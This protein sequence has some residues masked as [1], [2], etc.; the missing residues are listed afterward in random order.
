MRII[1][2]VKTEV[3]VVVTAVADWFK[4]LT[5]KA[6]LTALLLAVLTL[7]SASVAL[8]IDSFIGVQMLGIIAIALGVIMIFQTK[9]GC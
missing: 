8:F 6:K 1:R 9:E 4:S 2:I 5:S 3:M 7:I